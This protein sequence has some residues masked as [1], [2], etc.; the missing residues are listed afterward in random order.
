MRTFFQSKNILHPIE[1]PDV[2]LTHHKRLYS[3]TKSSSHVIPSPMISVPEKKS[4]ARFVRIR[5]VFIRIG[6]ENQIFLS[7]FNLK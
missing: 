7:Y 2:G 1:N 5:L 6:K 3:R 4:N